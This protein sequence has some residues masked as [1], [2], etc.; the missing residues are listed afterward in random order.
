MATDIIL[1]IYINISSYIATYLLTSRLLNKHLGLIEKLVYSYIFHLVNIIISILFL[2]SFDHGINQ[3]NVIIVSQIYVF[4]AIMI[5][6]NNYKT[7]F[8]SFLSSLKGINKI[9]LLLGVIFMVHILLSIYSIYVFVPNETDTLAYHLQAPPN[10]YQAGNLLNFPSNEYRTTLF[11]DNSNFLTLWLFLTFK[12][13][14]FI[15]FGPYSFLVFATLALFML[16]QK[17][18]KDTDRN[19]A[20][21][22]LLCFGDMSLNSSKTFMGDIQILSLIIISLGIFYSYFHHKKMIYLFF[23]SLSTG[24]LLGA[25]SSGFICVFL[26]YLLA[27]YNEIFCKQRR[28]IIK[29]IILYT[30]SAVICCALGGFYYFR[31][32]YFFHNPFYGKSVNFLNLFSLPGMDPQIFSTYGINPFKSI[33]SLFLNALQGSFGL[34]FLLFFIP[35]SIIVVLYHRKSINRLDGSFLIFP[36]VYSISFFIAL[37]STRLQSDWRYFFVIGFSGIVCLTLLNKF[38]EIHIAKF[39]YVCIIPFLLF[40]FFQEISTM[41]LKP[42]FSEKNLQTIPFYNGDYFFF[43]NN[44]PQGK[45][46]SYLLPENVFI[47]PLYGSRYQNKLYYVNSDDPDE[48]IQNFE[49]NHSEYFLTRKPGSDFSFKYFHTDFNKGVIELFTTTEAT[50]A[51]N[52]LYRK[53]VI[54][55]I[56]S[57]SRID[58]YKINLD[59]YD[60]K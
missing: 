38:K 14:V 21:S 28:S 57:G 3:T 60:K 24:L 55:I 6:I 30:Y 5:S 53:G 29:L 47:Y 56:G 40:L 48:I 32:L 13:D 50:M 12:S 7:P 37:T 27:F 36:F 41:K 1:G 58:F 33:T 45:T 51:V 49:N 59:A 8:T 54:T 25:K 31:N 46:L 39:L 4:F 52:E 10:W 23:F 44:I 43:F 42:P 34:Q 15:E 11:A 26:L 2:N 22:L 9:T 35:A 16:L 17:I 18:H 20:F 19:F